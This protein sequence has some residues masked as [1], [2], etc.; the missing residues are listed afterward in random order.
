MSIDATLTA[1]EPL[2]RV[3]RAD[4]IATLTSIAVRDSPATSL[5]STLIATV[6][7]RRVSRPL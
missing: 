2:V 5:G 6:R 3:A 7:S 4:G 1:A